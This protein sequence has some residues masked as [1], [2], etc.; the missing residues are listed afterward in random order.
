MNKEVGRFHEFHN[1]KGQGRHNK[2]LL[3]VKNFRNYHLDP[4][5]IR[6]RGLYI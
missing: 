3:R 4:P 6:H 1:L 2:L 5:A